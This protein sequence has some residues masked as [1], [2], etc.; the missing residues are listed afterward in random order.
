MPSNSSLSS[1]SSRSSHAPT[2]PGHGPHIP[3]PPNA[4][5]CFRMEVAKNMRQSDSLPR[6]RMAQETKATGEVW[7]SMSKEEKQPYVDMANE[8]DA[9]HKLLY[10]DYRYA[11]GTVKKEKEAAAAAR[12]RSRAARE[13]AAVAAKS[14]TRSPRAGPS[15]SQLR[16]VPYPHPNVNNVHSPPPTTRHH[17]VDVWPAQYGAPPNM[18]PLAYSPY[19][20]SSSSN[21]VSTYEFNELDSAECHDFEALYEEY[22][23]YSA[24]AE[25]SRRR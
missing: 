24:Y 12:E 5:I 21:S 19:A 4:F 23:D 18:T 6:P 14:K 7:K 15:S 10:P 20:P 11:P 16:L 2:V 3:R 17:P 8:L 13:R 9:T 22:L 1:T 25:G